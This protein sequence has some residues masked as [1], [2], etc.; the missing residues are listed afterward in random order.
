MTDVSFKNTGEMRVYVLFCGGDY[1]DMSVFDPFDENVGTKVFSPYYA[2]LV[3]HP[4][5]N[6]LFDTAGHPDLGTDP[7]SRMGAMADA[8]RVKMGPD[9]WVVPRLKEL[10]LSPE[11]VS[12]VI[13]SHLHFDHTGALGWFRHARILVQKNE[14]A[15]AMNPPVY[16]AGAFIRADFDMGLNWHEL[17]GEYDVF[18]DGKIKCIPTPGHTRGHQSLW[19]DLPSRPLFL[20]ADAHYLL[21]KLRQ[22]LMPGFLWSPDALIESWNR[23]EEIEKQTGARLVVTHELDFETSVP[24]SP[25]SFYS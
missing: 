16:Q 4:K 21:A 13:Q 7:R 9:D 23:I 3:T 25:G 10:G 5:G 20:L 8:F 2:Y 22:R 11:D 15:F 18:G 12:T 19:I 17:E 24:K 6:V 1:M 14:L